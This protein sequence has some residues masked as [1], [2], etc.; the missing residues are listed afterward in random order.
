M[1]E[2]TDH[3]EAAQSNND[4]MMEIERAKKEKIMRDLNGDNFFEFEDMLA[5]IDWDCRESRYQFLHEF[6]TLIYNWKGELPNLCDVLHPIVIER[7]LFDCIN[8]KLRD[9]KTYQAENFITYVALAGYKDKPK[10]GEDGKPLLRR[11]TPLHYALRRRFH[12]WS[13]V[14]YCLLKIYVRSEVHYTDE[15]G[16]TYFDIACMVGCYDAVEKLIGLGQDVNCLGRK[17]VVPPL[18]LALH[19]GRE[20]VVELL[21]R[22]GADPN[23]PCEHKFTPLHVIGQTGNCAY[24]FFGIIEELNLKVKVNA[25]N[26]VGNAP[27]HLALA[28]QRLWMSKWLLKNGADPNLAN[29]MGLTPLHIICKTEDN[30]RL[31]YMLFEITNKLNR[32]VELDACD[33]VGNTPLHTAVVNNNMKLAELLLRKGANPNSANDK[34]ETPLHII[35]QGYSKGCAM[36]RLFFEV[37]GEKSQK[38]QVNARDNIESF[39]TNY[40]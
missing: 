11:T 36:A 3:P 24:T 28:R 38:V 1:Y 16:Y 14:I 33:N 27:L 19:C 22:N 30:H 7:L 13:V 26:E 12:K 15:F 31:G 25:R 23:S 37:I 39:L 10:V 8:L 20:A 6:N 9:N 21:L 29:A 2:S 18:H 32:H 40:L 4:L 34:G 35:C 17:S 5:S